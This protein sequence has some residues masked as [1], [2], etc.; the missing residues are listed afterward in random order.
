MLQALVGRWLAGEDID[1]A[2]AVCRRVNN[3]G[4]GAL[5][6][7]IGED[8]KDKARVERSV[9]TYQE[10]LGI[11][12]SEGLRA[13]ISLKLTGIGLDIG[14][15]Y[16]LKNLLRIL[17]SSWGVVVW[18]DME[19]PEHVQDTLE[20]CG[21]AFSHYKNLAVTLQA[22]L[23]RSKNDLLDILARKGR[24]RLVKGAYK[25]DIRGWHEMEASFSWLMRILFSRGN[26]FAIAT[27]DEGLLEEAQELQARFNRD[28]EFQF[29]R[30]VG[31]KLKMKLA[32]EWPVSDYTPFGTDALP[33]L[34]RWVRE[35]GLSVLWSLLG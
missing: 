35:Q 13:G 23:R 8:Y 20:L 7:Y 21:E 22:N 34:I 15:G 24:V 12:R 25:G 17:E 6:N 27:N 11:I 10:V 18:I 26:N 4:L 30:G 1:S 19:G 31:R 9:E 28:F 33:Y 32:K 3:S 16:C 2:V 29:L 14:K 5:L